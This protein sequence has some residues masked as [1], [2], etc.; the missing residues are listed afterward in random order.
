MKCSRDYSGTVPTTPEVRKEGN[1]LRIFFD[2]A[3]EERTNTDGTTTEI[4]SCQSV[5]IIGNTYGDIVN[6][7]IKDKYSDDKK[8]AI[9]LDYRLATEDTTLSDAKKTEYTTNYND[10]QTWRAH[11]KEIAKEVLTLI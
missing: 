8:D 3:K 5:D 11:A 2:F 4:V 10:F 7:I 6:A 9:L 1:L